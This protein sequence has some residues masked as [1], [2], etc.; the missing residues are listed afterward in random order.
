MFSETRI[1][2]P[3]VELVEVVIGATRA[4][5]GTRS[6]VVKA[7]GG[8]VSKPKNPPVL[9][10]DVF[11]IPPSL[12]K[13]LKKTIGDAMED[14]VSWAKSCV[15]EHGAEMIA[16]ELVSTNPLGMNRSAEEAVETVRK[17]L[18]AVDAPLM[19]CGSGNGETDAKLL[20]AVAAATE[21]ERCILST[22]TMENYKPVVAAAIKYGHAVLAATSISVDNAVALNRKLI[23]E[24]LDRDSIIIDP[25]SCALGYGFEYSYSVIERL[26]LKALENN[27]LAQIPIYSCCA[28]SW[29]A[30]TAQMKEPGWGGSKNVGTA[31]EMIAGIAGFMAGANMVHLI[32]PMVGKILKEFIKKWRENDA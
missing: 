20:P 26:K 10:F 17:V 23:R 31:G 5:G 12:P 22:V 28:N 21:G 1:D 11:D 25:S 13:P 18:D 15:E 8:E 27:K 4:D 32:D 6:W 19:I 29:A 30:R 9:V 16:L 3:A 24:G 2:K 14:P 7:G